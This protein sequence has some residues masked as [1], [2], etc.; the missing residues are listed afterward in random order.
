MYLPR[1]GSRGDLDLGRYPQPYPDISGVDLGRVSWGDIGAE[2]YRV[3]EKNGGDDGF[4]V[5][6][7][8]EL[9]S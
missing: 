1:R 9:I 5:G 2:R 7:S 4:E 8:L 3:E 6:L